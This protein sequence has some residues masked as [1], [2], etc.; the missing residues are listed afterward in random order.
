[1]E[2]A[3]RRRIV[4]LAEQAEIDHVA[5]GDH[6]SFY[7]GAGF[8]GLLGASSVLAISD[9]LGSNTGVF[10]MIST[11]PILATFTVAVP[12]W[13]HQRSHPPAEEPQNRDVP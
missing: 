1:M 9:R 12:Y 6:V 7:V 4:R 10:A 2:A 8:D 11:L 13:R 5:V 3:E